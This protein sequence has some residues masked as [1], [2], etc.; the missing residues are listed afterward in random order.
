[1]NSVP[2]PHGVISNN[3]K[4]PLEGQ[5]HFLWDYS[6]KLRE[7]HHERGSSFRRKML[8]HHSSQGCVKGV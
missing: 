8:R 4:L 1:M 7:E 2:L 3:L 6:G 5:K